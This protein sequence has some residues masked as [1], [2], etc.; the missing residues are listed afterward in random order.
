MEDRL[1]M[2]FLQKDNTAVE[3]GLFIGLDLGI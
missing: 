1:Y 2:R 3:D